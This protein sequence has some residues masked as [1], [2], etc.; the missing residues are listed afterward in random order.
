MSAYLQLADSRDRL[1][2]QVWDNLDQTRQL[3]EQE[4]QL[5]AGL[6]PDLK[7]MEETWKTELLKRPPSRLSLQEQ[8]AS[9][10]AGLAALPGRAW[11]G[12]A[13]WRPRGHWEPF[14]GAT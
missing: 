3:L 12:S 1:A 9:L 5:L 7:K 6:Q 13:P 11:P 14:S 8:L 10:L 4:R 2:A